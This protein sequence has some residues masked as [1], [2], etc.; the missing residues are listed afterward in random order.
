MIQALLNPDDDPWVWAV[1][2]FM[3]NMG[4]VEGATRLL[5]AE[6]TGSDQEAIFSDDLASRIRY[7]RKRFPRDTAERHAHATNVFTV[8]LRLCGFRNIVAHSPLILSKQEDGTVDI[9]GIISVSPKVPKNSG[10]IISLTELT[11]RIEESARVAQELLNMRGV[12]PAA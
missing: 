7:L 6:I 4:V 12:F 2:R 10:V 3:L 5:V 11:G 9:H 1:G 8:A